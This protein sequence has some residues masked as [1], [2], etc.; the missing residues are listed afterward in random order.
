MLSPPQIL[1][2]IATVL[3]GIL[4]LFGAYP[5]CFNY[6]ILALLALITVL[7]DFPSTA[8]FLTLEERAFVIWRKSMHIYFPILD[9]SVYPINTEYDNSSVG[10][11]EAFAVRHV[12]AAFTDWQVCLLSLVSQ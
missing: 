8:K 1:E 5:P 2:G 6:S 12:W 9:S 10:E 4:A 7:V 11:E 3:I